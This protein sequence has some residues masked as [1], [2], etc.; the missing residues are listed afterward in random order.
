[1]EWAEKLK[2]R[3]PGGVAPK[4]FDPFH[5]MIAHD[6]MGRCKNPGTR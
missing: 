4:D 2:I 1:M 5:E 3:L 6:L